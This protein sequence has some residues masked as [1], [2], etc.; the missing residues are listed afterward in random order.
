MNPLE[1][2]IVDRA[3]RIQVEPPL[4]GQIRTFGSSDPYEFRTINLSA[5]GALVHFGKKHVLPFSKDTL[6]E[7]LIGFE[8]G[9]KFTYLI[10][11]VARRDTD[12]DQNTHLAIKILPQS[13]QQ[14]EAWGRIAEN[15]ASVA[16]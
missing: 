7:I 1:R 6:V 10:G 9:D 13:I 15:S 11:K 14:K 12:R 4:M 3:P 16:H 2:A 8:Y 5:S